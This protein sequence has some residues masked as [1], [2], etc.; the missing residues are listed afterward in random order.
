MAIKLSRHAPQDTPRQ[1][2]P[3]RWT[4]SYTGKKAPRTGA[5]N[6]IHCT[7]FLALDVHQCNLECHLHPGRLE[8]PRQ[9]RHDVHRIRAAH[10]HCAH[11]HTPTTALLVMTL[12]S[13]MLLHPSHLGR[14]ELPGQA[15][16]DIHRIRAAHTDRAH[17]QAARVG[18][19]RVRADH[20]AA[21]ER[22]VLQHDLRGRAA[23][24]AAGLQALQW[25][26]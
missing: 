5:H 16:H 20:H 21:R 26:S 8:L 18:R 4:H 12:M 9:A 25:Y 17:A 11:A 15:R 14:L 6:S 1:H 3:C 22:I 23:S 2:R 7:F 24:A 19:V 10:A 13:N